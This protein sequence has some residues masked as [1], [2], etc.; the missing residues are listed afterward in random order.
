MQEQTSIVSYEPPE[1][2]EVVTELDPVRGAQAADKLL[3]ALWDH[4]FFHSTTPR[5]KNESEEDYRS[6]C[7]AD[8][9]M[10]K[11]KAAGIT[12]INMQAFIA[13]ALRDAF[14]DGRLFINTPVKQDNGVKT[15]SGV[16]QI[17]VDNAHLD[18]ALDHT[19]RSQMNSII[20]TV[21]PEFVAKG[22]E[23]TD[24]LMISMVD[25]TGEIAIPE[26]MARV[27]PAIRQEKA[28]TGS[29]SQETIDFLYDRLTDDTV[30]IN[31]FEAELRQRK[32]LVPE[33]HLV[34]GTLE[35]LSD[36]K[37]KVTLILDSG[38]L[39]TFELATKKFLRLRYA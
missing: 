38:E 24:D 33:I 35:L 31:D 4:G 36:G 8:K 39:A 29:V 25:N 23:I 1:A 14:L 6:R 11:V 34:E 20:N 17:W 16:L 30:S 28:A 10:A 22:K 18:I 5:E 12:I 19:K 32:G 27:I 21:L 7:G 13:I 15:I 2:L 26:K 37:N 3:D 9:L